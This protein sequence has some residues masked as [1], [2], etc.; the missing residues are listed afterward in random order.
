MENTK[1]AFTIVVQNDD[2]GKR[3]DSFLAEA[4]DDVNRSRIADCIKLNAVTVNNLIKKPSYKVKP[5]DC[6]EG[7][8]PALEPVPFEPENIRLDI[9]H[10]DSDIAVINKQAGL[11]VHPAPGNWTGTL[12]QGLLYHFPEIGATG[13]EMR[14]GIVHRLDRDTSGVMVVAKH[15]KALITLAAMFKSRDVTKQYTAIVHG[16]VKEDSG[17][18]NHPIGRHPVDRKKMSIVSPKGKYAETHYRVLKRW[19]NAS[20][21][22]CDIK[23]GRTHQIRVHCLS[24]DHPLIGDPVYV[25]KRYSKLSA[26]VSRIKRQMLHS[27]FLKFNH[28]VTQQTMVFS[29]PLPNDMQELINFFEDENNNGLKD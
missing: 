25:M 20:V 8:I 6:I 16:N 15:T 17:V 18:I 28:P 19:E 12:V 5:G 7:S 22:Q 23:T 4:L 29:A 24:M 26:Y 3:L 10:E 1:G 13:D 2:F 14:P 9:I 21:L 11:V 27:S